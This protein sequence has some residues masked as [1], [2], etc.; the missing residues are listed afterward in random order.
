MRPMQ[1][2]RTCGQRVY[3]RPG[4]SKKDDIVSLTKET[5]TLV[6]NDNIIKD[7][8]TQSVQDVVTT[9]IEIATSSA[10]ETEMGRKTRDKPR[11]E[12][13]PRAWYESQTNFLLKKA[14]KEGE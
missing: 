4:T 2:E 14:I 7:V 3:L 1:V 6:Q 12:Q 11:L 10:T 5:K 13:A 8:A 9:E